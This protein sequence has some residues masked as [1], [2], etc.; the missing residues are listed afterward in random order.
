[1]LVL[2]VDVGFSATKVLWRVLGRD[3]LN[4]LWLE[5]ETALIPRASLSLYEQ[6]Q[7][8][9]S[10]SDLTSNIW[11]EYGGKTYAVGE[12]ASR[13]FASICNFK[14]LK[15]ETAA[16]KIL[17]ACALVAERE[18]LGSSF[19]LALGTPLPWA[20]WSDRHR[21]QAVLQKA[22]S[23]Y[24]FRHRSLQVNLKHFYCLP[25]GGG[26]ILARSKNGQFHQKGQTALMLGYRDLSAVRFYKGEN[27]GGITQPI[28]FNYAIDKLKQVIPHQLTA[29]N[30][31]R[32][33]S[34][35]HHCGSR[36]QKAD[37][38]PLIGSDPNRLIRAVKTIRQEYW[39]VVSKFIKDNIA[40]NSSELVIGGGTAIYFREEIQ[41]LLEQISTAEI[42]WFGGAAAD[43]K[44]C[45]KTEDLNEIARICDPFCLCRDLFDK[46]SQ[47]N[48]AKTRT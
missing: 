18:N 13:N 8:A 4:L 39:Y 36:P 41:Q 5:P 43:I 11:V 30:I 35:V 23:N 2:T 40:A 12:L 32:V 21:L 6:S 10:R 1:M 31:G 45:F 34:I 20:E 29:E 15:C 22:L 14:E 37:L 46:L 48:Y 33:V 42:I 16:A 38:I 19:D 25:E 9:R 44:V 27:L 24:R 28:G 26:L 47:T 7:F 17:A 3:R